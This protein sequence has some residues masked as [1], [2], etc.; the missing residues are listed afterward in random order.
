MMRWSHYTIILFTALGLTGTLWR[1][2]EKSNPAL[3]PG[4]RDAKGVWHMLGTDHFGFD[5]ASGLLLGAKT[6]LWSGTLALSIA[7]LLGGLLGLLS[8]YFGN[9]RFHTTRAAGIMAF[10]GLI[11]ALFFAFPARQHLYQP[12]SEHGTVFVATGI[13]W[14]CVFGLAA[15]GLHAVL[16]Y[17]SIGQQRFTVPLDN[18]IQRCGEVITAAPA[19]VL[20]IA[21]V[22]V[23]PSRTL[24]A[25]MVLI[26]V[27]SWPGPA[28]LVRSAV[29]NIREADYIKAA[30]GL[31]FSDT[32]V[33]FR[34]ILPNV[35]RPLLTICALSFATAVLLEAS[36]SFLQLSSESLSILTWGKMLQSARDNITLWWVWLPP[37]CLITWL[38]AALYDLAERMK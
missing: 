13:A 18:L 6:S 27:I 24:A 17:L 11:P 8:G 5:V 4:S 23:L 26:G 1:G 33:L 28:R 12:L 21:L 30:R 19:L 14:L 10:F 29:M 16:R 32:R 15:W 34:H 36:I 31:G 2:L 37:G 35:V 22:A 7:L 3:P 20:L 25:I 9:D 38:V